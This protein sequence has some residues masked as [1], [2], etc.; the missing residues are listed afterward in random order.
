M[1]KIVIEA[2][3]LHRIS[4]DK[5]HLVMLGLLGMVHKRMIEMHVLIVF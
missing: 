1:M 2:E 5:K 3:I 4:S